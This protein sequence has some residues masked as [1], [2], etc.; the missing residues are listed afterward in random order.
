MTNK[1]NADDNKNNEIINTVNVDLN[2][3]IDKK[4][5]SE[6]ALEKVKKKYK[7]INFLVNVPINIKIELGTLKLKIKD[8]LNL[9]TDSVL[10]LDKYSGEPLNILVNESII[11]KGELVIVEERYGIRITDIIDNSNSSNC[12]N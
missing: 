10:T 6:V 1:N 3:K 4:G 5:I 11:A 9:S 7:N 12:L 8:L 2:K